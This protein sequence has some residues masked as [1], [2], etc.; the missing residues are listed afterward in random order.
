MKA[1]EYY[2]EY[3]NKVKEFNGDKDLALGRTLEAFIK[4]SIKITNKRNAKFDHSIKPVYEEI[5]KKCA[6]FVRILNKNDDEMDIREDAFKFFMKK[7]HPEMH[8]ALGW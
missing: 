5:N 7:I 8:A 1:K 3:L 4:E 6:S 2:D